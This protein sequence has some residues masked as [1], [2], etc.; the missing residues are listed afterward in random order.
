MSGREVYS[1]TVLDVEKFI[2]LFVPAIIA[3][4]SYI[5]AF[6][7]TRRLSRSLSNGRNHNLWAPLLYPATLVVLF[8]PS[9]I[10]NFMMYHELREG[11]DLWE[12]LTMLLT[13]SVGL[14]N[15]LVYGYQRRVHKSSASLPRP[16]RVEIVRTS[17]PEPLTWN[18]LRD[19]FISSSDDDNMR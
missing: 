6:K 8:L 7:I 5:Y 1:A 13:H 4:V 17:I 11:V 2:S 9:L 12:A 18:R 14:A 10:Y 15:A 3:L 16:S 19:R